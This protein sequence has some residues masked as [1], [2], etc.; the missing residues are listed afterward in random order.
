MKLPVKGFRD[1]WIVRCFS[2]PIR[3]TQTWWFGNSSSF[4]SKLSEIGKTITILIHRNITWSLNPLLQRSNLQWGHS[5]EQNID[6]CVKVICHSHR[7][8]IRYYLWAQLTVIFNGSMAFF[9]H[10]KVQN[11]MAYPINTETKS[12]FQTDVTERK[13]M[14]TT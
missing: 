6:V 14:I 10:F 7:H 13:Q 11:Q 3:K 12:V 9:V 4:G 5:T 8:V 2:G 1:P